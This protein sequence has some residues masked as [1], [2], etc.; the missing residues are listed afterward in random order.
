LNDKQVQST[1][2]PNETISQ[3]QK[4]LSDTTRNYNDII[5]LSKN[6]TEEINNLKEQLENEKT[7]SNSKLKK[8][9]KNI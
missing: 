7:A 3:L 2:T 5:E 9:E 1:S 8:N 4:E 6:K